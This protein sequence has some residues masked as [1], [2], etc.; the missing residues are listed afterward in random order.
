MKIR[1]I[2][3]IMLTLF[4]VIGMHSYVFKQIIE[5]KEFMNTII[6]DEMYEKKD[7]VLRTV[8]VPIVESKRGQGNEIGN[9]KKVAITFDDGPS[10][11]ITPN[12]LDILE[13]YNARATFFLL[14]QNTLLNKNIV[15]RI[16]DSNHEIGNHS[17]SHKDFTSIGN[18]E[19]MQEIARTDHEIFEII[20]HKPKYVRVPYGSTNHILSTMIN[21]P[22]I[23]WS[24]DS[25]DWESKNKYSIIE[26]IKNGLHPG[27]IVL[28]H[29]IQAATAEA[30]PDVLDYIHN[31]GYEIVTVSEI[32]D[33]PIEPFE[34]YSVNDIRKK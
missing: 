16:H 8:E 23:Q 31:E 14:G 26:E 4:I 21:R 17:F 11:R 6:K 3:S 19:I 29:D 18:D 25:K 10:E 30:L 2:A 5:R 34:Y 15:K 32:L 28:M 9:R 13:R 33:Y 12:I 7:Y 1:Y 24:V 27:A 22:L 20:G